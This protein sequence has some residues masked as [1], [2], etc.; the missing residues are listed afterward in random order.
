MAARAPGMLSPMTDAGLLRS[1]HI[2]GDPLLLANVWDVGSAMVVV[3][4]GFPVIATS[5]AAVAR[6]LGYDDGEKMGAD[7]ALGAIG[8]IA[9][10][11]A[12]PVTADFEA[13]YGLDAE[14]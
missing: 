8:R 4:A 14:S 7:V 10:A 3:D 5:S 11:V 9:A 12:V 6:S 13:G 1:L 2:P